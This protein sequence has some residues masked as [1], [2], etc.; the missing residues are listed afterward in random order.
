MKYVFR[1][2]GALSGIGPGCVRRPPSTGDM[3][4]NNKFVVPTLT[5]YTVL[6]QSAT[7]QEIEEQKR[8]VA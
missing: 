3:N 6:D 8:F 1:P 2:V 4:D 7:I 5:M